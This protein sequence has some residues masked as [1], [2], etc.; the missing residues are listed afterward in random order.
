MFLYNPVWVR[1]RSSSGEPPR[2]KSVLPIIPTP[3]PDGKVP[4]LT[5]G[6]DPTEL[7]P[8]DGFTLEVA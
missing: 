5:A 6:K 4:V 7:T 2:G 8:E 3:P 1:V